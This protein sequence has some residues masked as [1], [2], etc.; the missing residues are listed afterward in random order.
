MESQPAAG[1]SGMA[2]IGGNST[3][4]IMDSHGGEHQRDEVPEEGTIT[5]PTSRGRGRPPRRQSDGMM[6]TGAGQ[7]QDTVRALESS[8][9]GQPQR[10]GATARA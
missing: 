3:S 5:A 9:V 10:S 7:Q 6:G 8:P 2:R 1:G 4:V